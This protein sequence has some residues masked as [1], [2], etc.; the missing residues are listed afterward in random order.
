MTGYMEIMATTL[1]GKK[2][3]QNIYM[4]A[5]A[6]MML[7]VVAYLTPQTKEEKTMTTSQE[8]LATIF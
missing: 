6:M 2:M 4:S 8:V 7:Q 5:R 1:A 3:K